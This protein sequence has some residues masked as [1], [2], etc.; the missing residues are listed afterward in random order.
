MAWGWLILPLLRLPDCSTALINVHAF[1]G[2]CAR[3]RP[4]VCVSA[5]V[6]GL[7]QSHG[8]EQADTEW[9][10]FYLPIYEAST[11]PCPFTAD[12]FQSRSINSLAWLIQ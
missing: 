8:Q 5:R 2:D 4:R 11:T 6:W 10:G 3:A 12:T 7:L 9:I 1:H